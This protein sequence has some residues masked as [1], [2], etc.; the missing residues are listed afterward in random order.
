[1]AKDKNRGGGGKSPEKYC[2]GVAPCDICSFCGACREEVEVLF[3]GIG[4]ARICNDCI[5]NGHNFL[6]D[7]ALKPKQSVPKQSRDT[8]SPVPPRETVSKRLI[9]RLF[10]NRPH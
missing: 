6:N 4:G 1:M 8:S 2:D 9:P 10:P 3:E 7:P 5:E